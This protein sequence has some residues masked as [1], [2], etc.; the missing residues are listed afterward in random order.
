MA[1]LT[2]DRSGVIKVEDRNKG[3]LSSWF[4]GSSAPVAVGVPVSTREDQPQT[5]SSSEATPASTSRFNFFSSSSSPRQAKQQT[6][7]LPH[8]MLASDTLLTLSIPTALYPAGPP[9]PNAAFSPSAYKNLHL[10]AVGTLEKLHTAYKLRT[11]S[12]HEL[13]A[14]NEAQAEELEEAETRAQCLRTQLE[15]MARRVQDQDRAVEELVL[16]LAH[17][18]EARAKEADAREK[19]IALIKSSR[20][21]AEG[22]SPPPDGEGQ[23]EKRASCCSHT[24]SEE[25]LGIRFAGSSLGAHPPSP[26]PSPAGQAG[27]K[28]HS[29]RISTGSSTGSEEMESDSEGAESVFSRSMS[30]GV[31]SS[32]ASTLTTESTPEV[33]QARFGRVV[34]GP[35]QARTARQSQSQTSSPSAMLA[36]GTGRRATQRPKMEQRP[37]TFQR[38]MGGISSGSNPHLGSQ[39]GYGDGDDAGFLGEGCANCRGQASSVAWDTVGLLRVENR[40]LKGRVGELEGA[41]EGALGLCAGLGR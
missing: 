1:T 7:R 21:R 11:L 39:L 22:V 10:N 4:S 27:V 15:E 35:G 24:H 23:R 14:E 3:G 17:E 36:A 19:S 29:W 31:A 8:E 26:S 41:V 5:A 25:D 28:K 2:G 30:P 12:V 16:Q 38:L 37:S 34:D 32:A 18:K 33:L 40:G 6:I 9:S 20:E 13:S